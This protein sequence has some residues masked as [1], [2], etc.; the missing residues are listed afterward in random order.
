MSVF[1][2]LVALTQQAKMSSENNDQEAQPL[3]LSRMLKDAGVGNSKPVVLSK[4]VSAAD[5]L[6]ATLSVLSHNDKSS[7]PNTAQDAIKTHVVVPASQETDVTGLEPEV[8]RTRKGLVKPGPAPTSEANTSTRTSL[9]R[10]GRTINRNLFA[11]SPSLSPPKATRPAQILTQ[12]QS[13]DQREERSEREEPAADAR[14]EPSNRSLS[15]TD[16]HNLSTAPNRRTT[17]RPVVHSQQE[18]DPPARH[19]SRSRS[20][21]GRVSFR[22]SERR[23]QDTQRREA[24]E[25]RELKLMLQTVVNNQAILQEN[26]N[27]QAA[28][29]EELSRKPQGGQRSISAKV[30]DEMIKAINKVPMF[31]GASDKTFNAFYGEFT[32]VATMAGIPQEEWLKMLHQKMSGQ[33]LVYIE[34]FLPEGGVMNMTLED[35]VQKLKNG[36]FGEVLTKTQLF[37]KASAIQQNGASVM[38][39]LKKKEQYLNNLPRDT[40]GWIKTSL[41]MIGMDQGLLD[42][43]AVNHNSRDGSYDSYDEFRAKVLATEAHMNMGTTGAK[44]R[45]WGQQASHHNQGQSHKPFQ[46]AKPRREEDVVMSGTTPTKPIPK[47]RQCGQEGHWNAAN[48]ACPKHNPN[49]VK[50]MGKGQKRA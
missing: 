40:G 24:E 4:R 35:Y 46:Q 43:V 21:A 9:P 1:S 27:L 6:A 2:H 14:Y 36:R 23:R 45:T 29:I 17:T 42:K 20:P 26:N 18:N 5:S 22:E 3:P 8:T 13:D 30:Q 12:T 38:Q 16:L 44:K 47:C 10:T 7:A 33:A 34:G 39:F 19:V 49:H 25:I 37:Q 48:K 11:D 28:R 50:V 41:A 32:N 15:S 31:D